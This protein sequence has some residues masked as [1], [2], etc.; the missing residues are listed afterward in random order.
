MGMGI[1]AG[2]SSTPQALLQKKKQRKRKKS[3]RGRARRAGGAA[4]RARLGWAL[5][6]FSTKHFFQ[7]DEKTLK[8]DDKSKERWKIDPIE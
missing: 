7:T 6:G 1:S 5:L 8:H 3:P 2:S 4:E